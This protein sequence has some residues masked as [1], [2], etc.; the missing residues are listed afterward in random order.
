MAAAN[1]LIER[2]FDKTASSDEDL[3]AMKQGGM[4]VIVMNAPPVRAEL[5]EKPARV[6]PVLEAEIV[7]E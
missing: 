4:K 1:L 5:P 7:K 3:E 2:G 6:V